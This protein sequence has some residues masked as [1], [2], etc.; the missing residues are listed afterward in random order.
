MAGIEADSAEAQPVAD[1]LVAA[2]ARLAGRA[3]GQEFLYMA[4][5]PA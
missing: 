4:H 1:E 3:D 5:G 2:Y